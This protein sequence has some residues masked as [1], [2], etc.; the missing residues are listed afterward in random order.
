M[1]QIEHYLGNPNLKASG[2]EI[3]F[4]QE[5]MGEYLKCAQ[6]PIYFIEKYVKIVNLDLGLTNFDMYDFQR[7]IIQKVHD[8]RFVICKMPRQSGKSTTVI[9]YLLHYILF[10]S[11]MNLAILA[12]K[13]A[14]ARELLH[15]LQTAYEHLPF[16]L[17]QGVISWNKGSIELE[18][19]SR[20]LASSTSSSAV[21]GGSFNLIFL[22]EFAFVPYEIAD[23]FF[24]SVY[25]TISS[26]QNTKVLMV[27]TPKGMNQFYK[28]WTDA[29]HG[30][31]S[32]VPINVHWSQVPGRDEKWKEETIAN[33]S[34]E[35]FRQEFECDFLGSAG[36]LIEPERLRTL[37]YVDP[38]RTGESGLKVYEEPQ[39]DHTYVIPV[40]VSRG[41]GGDYH[42]FS[43][44]DITKTPY[45]VVATFKNNEMPP[46]VYPSAIFPVAKHY[47]EAFVFVEVNDIGGQVA[48][49]LKND[50]E[51]PSMLS[52]T[53][54][55]RKGQVLG[56]GFGGGQT[57]NGLRTTE[58]VKRVG[59][60]V[61]KSL[62][63]EQKFIIEDYDIIKELTTFIA[64]KG[65]YEAEKGHHD[66]LVMTL[67]MFCWM[68]SQEYFKE[69]LDMDIRKDLYSDQI[70]NIE[71]EMTP[72]GFIDDG[73]STNDGIRNWRDDSGTEWNVIDDNDQANSWG[74]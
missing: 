44:I 1:S 25:P 19:G 72:F 30:R 16:W 46:M 13:Q 67:V 3:Q 18:N 8:N 43:V 57:V 31:N 10:N 58:P 54:R 36:T 47:N 48:D 65:S 62:I 68:T 35:Q 61:L 29:E 33:T 42:A 64:T 37:A 53:I 26:G 39:K 70:K 38:I 66:D 9:S 52:T 6:N 4:T 5:E 60:S 59:C 71:E 69:L 24:S 23:E 55:G 27:S 17:Q 51:Y 32:Y 11:E 22:D 73:M 2:V 40:D 21:R 7:D 50:Y 45:K 49:I 14:T 74:W 15:R 12:N 56:E 63:N 41:V 20:I 28:F 34:E